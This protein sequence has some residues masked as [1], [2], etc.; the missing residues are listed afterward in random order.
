[1]TFHTLCS[2]ISAQVPAKWPKNQELHQYLVNF[3]CR[4]W[5]SKKKAYFQC[6]VKNCKILRSTFLMTLIAELVAIYFMRY[7]YFVLPNI[8]Q[9]HIC[10]PKSWKWSPW[11]NKICIFSIVFK[12][13]QSFHFFLQIEIKAKLGEKYFFFLS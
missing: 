2:K 12:L 4:L 13:M 7:C 9:W 8:N 11:S 5:N 1:M 6:L 3:K 10:H